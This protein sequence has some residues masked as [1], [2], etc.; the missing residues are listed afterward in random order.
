M[1]QRVFTSHMLRSHHDVRDES[2]AYAQWHSDPK[3]VLTLCLEAADWPN[4]FFI[5]IHEQP[6]VYLS[7]PR[8][9][10]YLTVMPPAS[11]EEDQG[12]HFCCFA[13][14]ERSPLFQCHVIT[15]FDCFVLT[16]SI[17]HVC[18]GWSMLETETMFMPLLP[19]TMMRLLHS[20]LDMHSH[21]QK[22]RG[23]TEMTGVSTLLSIHAAKRHFRLRCLTKSESAEAEHNT[24]PSFVYAG[25]G[26]SIVTVTND[27]V[28]VSYQR[29]RRA[30]PFLPDHQSDFAA[31]VSLEQQT[32]SV[33]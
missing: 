29:R 2:T 9:G 19:S 10:S 25:H 22:S 26:D 3:W 16:V 11:Y 8:S 17:E 14:P 1:D 7:E 15:S 5:K 33:S 13:L 27:C 18:G 20:S 32:M 23:T 4:E 30:H 31:R 28:N 12:T 6:C 21:I 24:V